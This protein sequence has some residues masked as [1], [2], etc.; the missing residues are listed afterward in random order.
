MTTSLRKL[1]A[2]TG[3]SNKSSDWLVRALLGHE[4]PTRGRTCL[5]EQMVPPTNCSDKPVRR[6][7]GRPC[8]RTAR[9][10]RSENLSDR[11]VQAISGG[12]ACEP[13]CTPE[14]IIFKLMSRMDNEVSFT[15]QQTIRENVDLTSLIN[16]LDNIAAYTPLGKKKNNFINRPPTNP[17][18]PTNDKSCDPKSKDLGARNSNSDMKCYTCNQQGHNSRNCPKSS[19]KI[20]QLEGESD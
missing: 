15:A 13:Q 12:S 9:T 5:P 16:A 11:S 4:C 17:A 6:L 3:R 18:G 19:R 10:S 8:P 7:V 14:I 20:T 1:I 2:R